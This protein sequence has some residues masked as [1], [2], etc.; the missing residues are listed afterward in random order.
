MLDKLLRDASTVPVVEELMRGYHAF[1]DEAGK[2]LMRE[3][4]CAATPPGASAPRSAMRSPFT[5]GRTST[6]RRA[7]TIATPPS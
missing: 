2:V 7:S 1:L 5:P 3:G 4:A 6:V